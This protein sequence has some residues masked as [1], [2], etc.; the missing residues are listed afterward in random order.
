MSLENLLTNNCITLSNAQEK[1]IVSEILKLLK[2]HPS[3]NKNTI[4][5][6]IATFQCQL[7]EVLDFKNNSVISKNVNFTGQVL[8]SGRL[9]W[10][11]PTL[12]QIEIPE[13][14]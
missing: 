10:G 13:L 7:D 2:V 9:I 5:S 14:K 11:I 4:K 6:L 12:L 1:N 3:P 8:T